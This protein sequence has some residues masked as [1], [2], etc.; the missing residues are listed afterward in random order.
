MSDM[1]HN[2]LKKLRK[3]NNSPV[4]YGAVSSG[5]GERERWE[6]LFKKGFS[7]RGLQRISRAGWLQ[8]GFFFCVSGS[9]RLPSVMGQQCERW[10]KWKTEASCRVEIWRGKEQD[11]KQVGNL[12]AKESQHGNR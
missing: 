8:K 12:V 9:S 2:T 1:V 11:I 3:G 5:G 6:G 7:S 10:D 4:C